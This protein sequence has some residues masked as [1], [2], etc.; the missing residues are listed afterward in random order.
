M[1]L[2]DNHPEYRVYLRATVR[3]SNK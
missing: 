3:F 1:N 2:Q